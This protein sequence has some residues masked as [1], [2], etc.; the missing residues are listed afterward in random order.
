MPCV[1]QAALLSRQASCALAVRRTLAEREVVA[2]GHAPAHLNCETLERLF[3][4][5]ATF[6]LRLQPGAPLTHGTVMR[7]QCGGLCGL[8]QAL[9]APMCDV[10]RLIGMAH[11]RYGSLLQLPW[12]RIVQRMLDWQPRRRLIRP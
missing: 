3:V 5:R 12:D 7:L 10:N 1:F 9:Q 6:P 2:C 8:Q 11:D 4:E